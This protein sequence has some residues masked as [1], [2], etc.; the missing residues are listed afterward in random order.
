MSLV[1]EKMN[2]TIWCGSFSLIFRPPLSF[3]V[4]TVYIPSNAVCRYK[5]SI[6]FPTSI[7]CESC[8]CICMCSFR[9]SLWRALEM[10]DLLYFPFP[11]GVERS[12]MFHAVSYKMTIKLYLFSRGIF[13][14]RRS[15]SVNLMFIAC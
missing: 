3:G 15:W 1:E 12:K 10:A 8:R 2:I 6:S 9:L 13:I 7:Y 5:I 4:Y 11:G 14:G